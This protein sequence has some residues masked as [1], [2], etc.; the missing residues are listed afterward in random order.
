MISREDIEAA[1]RSWADAVVG[2]GA[3]GNWNEAHS[4]AEQLV[5]SLY[6]SEGLLFCPT[7]AAI[8]QF[9]HTVSA[10]VSYFVGRDEQFPEDGGFALEPWTSVRF[11]NHGVESRENYAMAMGNYFFGKGDGSE[12]KVEYSFVYVREENGGLKIQLHHSA[13]PYSR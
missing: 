6:V 1:Q 3:A 7:K 11:E 2:V 9:R 12:L 5:Q 10:S 13:M 8:Q 4:L